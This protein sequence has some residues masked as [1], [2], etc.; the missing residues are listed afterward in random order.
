MESA[1]PKFEYGYMYFS[2]VP[3]F[4]PGAKV[5]T[6][7]YN[8]G[9]WLRNDQPDGG[10]FVEIETPPQAVIEYLESLL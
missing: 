6:I 5:C 10:E 8:E 4:E 3:R 7:C 9:K 1:V 2:L